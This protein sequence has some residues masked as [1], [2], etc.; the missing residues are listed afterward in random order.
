MSIKIIRLTII[1]LVTV[2]LSFVIIQATLTDLTINTPTNGTNISGS[3]L[4]NATVTGY[5]YNV[6]FYNSTDALTW[7]EI[8]VVQNYTSDQT[9]FNYS[10]DTS[11]YTAGNI[12]INATADNSSE[13][14]SIIHD[15]I[16]IDNT[17]PLS[18]V[19]N[20][21]VEG[22]NSTSDD[23]TFNFTAE[24]AL[25]P[26]NYI[27]YVDGVENTTGSA[28]NGTPTTVLVENLT[29]GAHNWSVQANDSLGNINTTAATNSFIIDTLTPNVTFVTPSTG[30]SNT[31]IVINVT[32]TDSGS[33]VSTVTYQYE[34]STAN[35][36]WIT[37]SN[38][39]GDYWNGTL[40]ITDVVD[41]NYTIW[42]NATDYA[43]LSNTTETVV[44]VAMDDTI[45][46][47]SVW[48][49]TPSSVNQG[50]T[51]TCSCV[52][53]DN[54]DPAPTTSY[55]VNPA[56]S[57]TGTFTVLC[58]AEDVAGNSVDSD[59]TEYTVTA[60]SGSSSP[61]GSST[62]SSDNTV[63]ETDE[64]DEIIVPVIKKDTPS[65]P[66]VVPQVVEEQQFAPTITEEQPNLPAVGYWV[67][68]AV[69]ITLF[70]LVFYW[71]HQSSTTGTK[72]HKK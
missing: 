33:G 36:S 13:F 49:C 44:N 43:G 9:E 58:T 1:S 17:E 38:T 59:G 55:V 57:A 53:A 6:T 46:T 71:T 72:K 32:V 62:S 27:L 41:D 14:L 56:T 70:G 35:S 16:T 39:A 34:N 31:S 45:P 15:T 22:A 61:S 7:T 64:E 51:V 23:V 25:L 50:Q 67:L 63:N 52:V 5:A 8:F 12:Y 29:E 68:A 2:L 54:I 11:A 19:L 24:D 4:L 28:N 42:I 66:E 65:K 37:M 60:T 69:C 10:W 40:V 3:Y 48:D 18:V 26:M 30:Y 47:F 20:A 21:P